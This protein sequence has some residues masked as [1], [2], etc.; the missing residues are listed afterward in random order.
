MS[1]KDMFHVSNICKNI[2][3]NLTVH[4]NSF[5]SNIKL[6]ID[7]IVIPL[8]GINEPLF[9]LVACRLVAFWALKDISAVLFGWFQ[10]SKQE[11]P[12][13]RK[14]RTMKPIYDTSQWSAEK[15]K[16]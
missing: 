4:S 1:Q 12:Y 13:F 14:L 15:W 6:W 8:G 5:G 16:K 10:T 11:I 7:N 2:F 9:Y 3:D